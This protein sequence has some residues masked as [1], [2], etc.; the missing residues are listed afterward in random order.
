MHETQLWS[1]ADATVE[2]DMIG[3]LNHV[4]IA[5]P[6]LRTAAVMYRNLLGAAAIGERL[7]LP[8]QG[9][10]V[11]FIDLPNSQLE[12][13]EPLGEASP[14]WG[15]L[16][17]YPAGGQHHICFEVDDILIARDTLRERGATVLGTG[18]PRLGAHGVPVIF[19]HPR[20]TDGVLIELM[21]QPVH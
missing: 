19:L 17:R 1:D 14:I 7:E 2:N 12:L 5:T 18:E 20:D 9:V 6:L 16:K 21:S 8:E 15:F 3:R 4:G 13:I 10:A 11:C